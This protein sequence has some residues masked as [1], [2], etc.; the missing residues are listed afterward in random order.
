MKRLLIGTA[1]AAML[2][3]SVSAD[4][5]PPQLVPDLQ[6]SVNAWIIMIATIETCS[7]WFDVSSIQA[8]LRILIRSGI[9]DDVMLYKKELA[10]LIEEVSGLVYATKNRNPKGFCQAVKSE[11]DNSASPPEK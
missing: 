11:L 1:L 4:G 5:I 8:D 6:R 9:L 7:P 10:P 2:T 3:S